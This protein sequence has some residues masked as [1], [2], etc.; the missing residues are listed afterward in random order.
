MSIPTRYIAAR[1]RNPIRNMPG[2]H[3]IRGPENREPYVPPY[4]PVRPPAPPPPP[5]TPSY[6]ISGTV[7]EDGTGFSA[8]LW[9]QSLGTYH[10]D[11]TGSYGFSVL[12]G[13]SG[14]VVP[15][16][17]GGT[18]APASRAYV[19]VGA[20]YVGQD[21]AFG[22]VTPTPPTP[23]P[24]W[25]I[26]GT[27]YESGTGKA[28]VIV[29]VTDYNS[30]NTA[31]NG[32]YG[33]QVANDWTGFIVPL[34][35]DTSGTFSPDQ[36]FLSN[37][38]TD[39]P[40]QN[41]DFIGTTPPTPAYLITGD[42]TEN[43]TG[44]SVPIVFD[45]LGTFQ[46]AAS[47]SYGVN[48]LAGY[49]GTATPVWFGGSFTPQSRVYTALS[50]DQLAQDYAFT[51]TSAPPTPTDCP[52]PGADV[53]IPLPMG[54]NASRNVIDPVNN[55]LWVI[56][57]SSTNVYYVDIMAGTYA[58]SVSVNSVYG[59]ATVGYDRTNEKVLCTTY[60]G[61]LAFINPVTKAVTFSDFKQ[62]EPNYHMLAVTDSGTAFVCDA[63]EAYGYLYMVDCATEKVINRWY[64]NGGGVN[65]IYTDSIAYAENIQKLVMMSSQPFNRWFLVFD[66]ATGVFTSS[67]LQTTSSF[68]YENY[69]V[70]A[71]GH[72]LM[73]RSGATAPE[74]VD[75]SLAEN[76]TILTSLAGG[77]TRVSDAT[78]DTCSN[79]LFVSDGNYAIYEYTLDGSYTLL[80]AFNNNEN[81][82]DPTGLAHSRAT[83][84]VYYEQWSGSPIP[85]RS[86]QATRTGTEVQDLS[87]VL[88]ISQGGGGTGEASLVGGNG[89][90]W[91]LAVG[92]ASGIQ[93]SPSW[94]AAF[95]SLEPDY[96]AKIRIEYTGSHFTSA[97]TVF[98]PNTT[99]VN[100]S[101][102]NAYDS[103][104]VTTDGS[105]G[106][107]LEVAGTVNYGWNTLSINTQNFTGFALGGTV[108]LRTEV[109]G[110]ISITPLTAP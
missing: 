31:A 45:S 17:V 105:F 2:T 26:S 87:W 103:F 21:F 20:D 51:G 11:S 71:T 69:Y 19:S 37:V 7:T 9:V 30:V 90:W 91:S 89:T 8:P 83:N 93:Y 52:I 46:S 40:N 66:P 10:S 65:P 79:R 4:P 58:G 64:L 57:E 16:R 41:F 14:V 39:T 106:G 101:V 74:V 81:G 99:N 72:M 75:I 61:S 88:D 97:L 100:A 32:S 23:T 25:L 56:D 96:P 68:S 5:P 55:L 108:Y 33:M 63:R 78:E 82:V 43:G 15:Y 36:R 95:T 28:N 3:Y 94:N 53:N 102:N 85:V 70:R 48:A 6:S 80:H 76:A 59:V 13:Y 62:R 84:L 29:V 54:N 35:Y 67:V 86:I 47:G 77:L 49:S 38:V 27:V 60:D 44:M 92:S 110:A 1:E 98:Q 12:A 24:T 18:F 73:T 104:S 107:I 42:V 50:G 109:N 34:W 22:S